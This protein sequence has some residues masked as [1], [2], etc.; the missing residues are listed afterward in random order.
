MKLCWI[1]ITVKDMEKSLHFYQKV[2]GLDISRKLKSGPD[3]EI[4]F[5][6]SGETKV[7]LICNKNAGDIT[8]GNNI[9]LG[10]EVDSLDQTLELLKK[11]NIPLYSGP[12]QP[13]PSIKFFYVLDPDGVKIQFVENIK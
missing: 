12:F 2:T 13:M 10:F 7:E 4:T 6:G 5:L 3:M 9:S 11:E 1:T 8:S